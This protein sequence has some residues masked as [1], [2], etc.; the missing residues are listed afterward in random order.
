LRIRPKFTAIARDELKKWHNEELQGQWIEGQGKAGLDV[1][2]A[3]A[4]PAIPSGVI[5][6]GPQSGGRTRRPRLV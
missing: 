3:A 2:D 6:A 4:A 1:K 5:A